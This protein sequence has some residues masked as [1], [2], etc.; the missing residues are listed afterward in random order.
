MGEE[1]LGP[2]RICPH[3]PE[4]LINFTPIKRVYGLYG[5]KLKVSS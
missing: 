1:R 4:V 3:Y 5:V 2:L